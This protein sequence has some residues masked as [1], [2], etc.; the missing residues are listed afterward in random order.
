MPP[1]PMRVLVTG[2]DRGQL[3]RELLRTVPDGIA[4][5]EGA[6]P[7]RS[8]GGAAPASPR[9]DIGDA[10]AVREAFARWQPHV[11]INAAAYTA[12]DRAESE[13]ELARRVNVEGVRHLAEA[14]A[15]S[16]ARVVNV[17]TD[18]VFG[19]AP[20]LPTASADAVPLAHG[21][22]IPEHASTDPRSVYGTTKR[23]GE[24][25]L[26]EVLG[27][28]GCTVRTAW[29]YASHGAN[30]V[31]TMLRLMKEREE[32]GVV[33]DQVGSPT[34]ARSLALALWRLVERDP[35]G[36]GG[37]LHWSGAGVASWYDLAVAVLE[38][39]RALGLLDARPRI[40]P[41]TT[42]DYPTPASRPASSVLETGRTRR[43]LD[44][45]ATHWRTELRAMLGELR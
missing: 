42:A 7:E 11:V 25:V 35:E 21:A 33:A 32:I 14:A 34:W 2:G 10:A 27:E 15:A 38:E 37:M 22:P 43:L 31:L 44:L 41:L 4:L 18:F 17:S 3:R 1:E 13:P 40:L 26:A 36:T 8:S 39:G 30:F 24:R 29:V 5:C 45:P 19:D 23:D 12:V 9:L 20:R 6:A 28:R 16:G